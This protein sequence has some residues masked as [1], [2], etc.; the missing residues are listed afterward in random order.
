MQNHGEQRLNTSTF[1]VIVLQRIMQQIVACR[2]GTSRVQV[3]D[4][5]FETSLIVP[6][7]N[8]A[9]RISLSII[10]SEDEKLRQKR[11]FCQE[12]QI[13]NHYFILIYN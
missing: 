6:A 2:L 3:D 13:R 11:T 5:M 10:R 12:D 1:I 9:V 4:S 7:M 8:S